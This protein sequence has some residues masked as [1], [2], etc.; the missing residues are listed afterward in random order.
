MVMTQD[1]L[2]LHEHNAG[3]QEAVLARLPQN[4][5]IFKFALRPLKDGAT[6][7]DIQAKNRGLLKV[8]SM[9]GILIS[10]NDSQWRWIFKQTDSRSLYQQFNQG[11][12]VNVTENVHNNL[13]QWVD[14]STHPQYNKTLR[15][16][17]FH[18]SAQAKKAI[19]WRFTSYRIPDPPMKYEIV[20]HSS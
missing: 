1:V 16:A 20:L 7:T 9:N 6:L 2:R 10:T 8:R 19:D 4:P 18:Y 13:H 11:Q 3:F 17:I 5:R 12:G 14:D 15:E